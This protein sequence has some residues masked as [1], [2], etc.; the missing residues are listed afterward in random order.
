MRVISWDRLLYQSELVEE[1]G[2]DAQGA[3][4]PDEEQPYGIQAC[5]S[6]TPVGEFLFDGFAR[7]NPA[8][9]HA[10]QYRACGKE[11]LR[12]KVVAEIE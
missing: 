9:K 2:N 10:R 11:V 3:D 1:Y 6:R 8:Y 7:N 4:E 12:R 5:G